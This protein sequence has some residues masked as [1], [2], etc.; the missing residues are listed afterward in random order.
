MQCIQFSFRPKSPGLLLAVL[1]ESPLSLAVFLQVSAQSQSSPETLNSRARSVVPVFKTTVCPP[2]G[3][4]T[5]SASY[6][7]DW[8]D[9]M[10]IPILNKSA[11]LM[12]HSLQFLPD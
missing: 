7:L 6:G 10:Q 12:L 5:A 4:N 9:C 1:V 2:L 3:Q 11:E 8:V